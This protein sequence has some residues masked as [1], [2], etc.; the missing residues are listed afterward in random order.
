MKTLLIVLLASA[1]V[2]AA[3]A[4]YYTHLMTNVVQRPS[5]PPHH[6]TNGVV[7]GMVTVTNVCIIVNYEGVDH[8]FV[9]KQSGNVTPIPPRG[10]R[11]NQPPRGPQK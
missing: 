9:L 7:R 6:T 10:A 2:W 1:S 8:T 3:D 4:V 11:T 5:G